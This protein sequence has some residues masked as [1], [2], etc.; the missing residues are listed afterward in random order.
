MAGEDKQANIET[1]ASSSEAAQALPLEGPWVLLLLLVPFLVLVEMATAYFRGQFRWNHYKVPLLTLVTNLTLSR[2]I[3]LSL[4]ILVASLVQPYALLDTGRSWYWFLYGYLVWEFAHFVYHWSAHKVRLLWC[5]HSTHHAPEHMNLSVSY[6]HF[7]LEESYADLIRIGICS[8]LGVD[9]FI[10]V[11][12]IGIDAIW[13]SWIHVS[14]EFLPDGRNGFLEKY[15]L[16]PSHHRLHH[17]RNPE[18]IDTNFCNLLNVWDRLFGTYRELQPALPPDYGIKRPMTSTH[19]FDAYFGEFGA[20]AADIKRATRWRDKL[21]YLVMPP[22]WKHDETSDTLAP[23]IA[24]ATPGPDT[25]L[26]TED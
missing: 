13:G 4:A 21:A 23:G 25:P 3:S 16:T 11:L 9:P 7:C 17:A 8:L 10:L 18:Y 12:V 19:F 6:S 22:H 2:F 20:L 14:E 24:N 1:M 5:L 26:Q 15:I